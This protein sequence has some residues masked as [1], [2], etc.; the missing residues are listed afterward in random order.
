MSNWNADQILLLRFGG[1][2]GRRL[3]FGEKRSLVERRLAD[4]VPGTGVHPTD[5]ILTDK[6]REILYAARRMMNGGV[7]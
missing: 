7:Q 6:G 3:S 4:A 2:L 1:D 5:F